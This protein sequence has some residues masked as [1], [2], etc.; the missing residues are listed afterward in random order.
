MGISYLA[1]KTSIALLVVVVD[2]GG[3]GKIAVDSP[4]APARDAM[5]RRGWQAINYRIGGGCC[6]LV[7][8]FAVRLSCHAIRDRAPG[9][10]EHFPR[11]VGLI[12][13]EW[14]LNLAHVRIAHNRW[15]VNQWECRAHSIYWFSEFLII[16]KEYRILDDCDFLS[17]NGL[18]QR[19]LSEIF[20][21][22]KITLNYC[23]LCSFFIIIIQPTTY[24]KSIWFSRNFIKNYFDN[25]FFQK[26]PQGFL[27]KCLWISGISKFV[28]KVRQW[29]LY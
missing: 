15:F 21:I 19:K 11:W 18:F 27:Q 14:T 5:V 22:F 29:F 25:E 2:G 4:S 28:W 6:W 16:K 17:P 3:G 10:R 20:S 23:T 12:R 1:D 24:C 8:K 9:T 26:L 13:V 7:C